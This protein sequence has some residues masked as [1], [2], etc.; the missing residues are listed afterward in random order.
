MKLEFLKNLMINMK[1]IFNFI[2]MVLI[3]HIFN[4]H[5]NIFLKINILFPLLFTLPK[6]IQMGESKQ[7]IEYSTFSTW[8]TFKCNCKFLVFKYYNKI[9]ETYNGKICLNSIW[10]IIFKHSC[11][12][13]LLCQSFSNFVIGNLII[14]SKK[15]TML[16][17]CYFQLF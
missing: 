13:L 9:Q 3:N 14:N 16:L 11:Y 15:N 5:S 2:T 6:L 7:I 8:C 1:I 12:P 17:L 4:M 10:Q